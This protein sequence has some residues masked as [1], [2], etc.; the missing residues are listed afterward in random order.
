MTLERTIQSMFDHYP[1]IFQTRADCLNHLFCVLGSGYYWRDG[2]LVEDGAREPVNE[3]VSGRASQR[4]PLT[5]R[6]VTILRARAR[7]EDSGET[8]DETAFANLPNDPI[9]SR[10]RR[11]RW[12]FIRRDAAGDERFDLLEEFVPLW[13]VPDDVRPDWRAGVDECL[14]MLREDGILTDDRR[15]E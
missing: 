15:G 10:P 4:T 8:L 9:P 1:L 6:S 5:A 13:H 14:A 11:E 7:A 2:E 3:L 12:Y